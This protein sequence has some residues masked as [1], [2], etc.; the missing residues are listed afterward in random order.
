MKK[1]VNESL[2]DFLNEEV[3]KKEKEVG[4]TAEDVDPK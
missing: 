1:L 4:I 3:L 2:Y